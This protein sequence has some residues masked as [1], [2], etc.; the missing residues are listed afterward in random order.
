[1]MVEFECLK[2]TQT[3]VED[4]ATLPEVGAWIENLRRWPGKLFEV[5]S[6]D[7]QIRPQPK[8]MVRELGKP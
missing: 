1:M 3:T 2:L 4:Q 8:V 7:D 6:I 5:V